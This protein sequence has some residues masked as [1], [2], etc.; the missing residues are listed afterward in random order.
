MTI[1]MLNNS[2]SESADKFRHLQLTLGERWKTVETFDSGDADIVIVPSISIDQREL[3]KIE[4]CEHY[5]ERL[6]F[7]LIR[8]QNPR[9]RLIYVTS[10]PLH[11]SI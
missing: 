1:Q 7:S 5:E 4:G 10:L 2:Y 3:Q 6:L 8:L 11:P 9:N